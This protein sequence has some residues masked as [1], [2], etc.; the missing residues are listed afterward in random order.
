MIEGIFFCSGVLQWYCYSQLYCCKTFPFHITP[1]PPSR[2]A[3]G[4]G[5]TWQRWVLKF[6]W[7]GDRRSTR[8]PPQS[9]GSACH[10]LLIPLCPAYLEKEAGTTEEGGNGSEGSSCSAAQLYRAN[11]SSVHPPC[12]LNSFQ[13]WLLWY[14]YWARRSCCCIAPSGLHVVPVEIIGNMN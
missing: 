4:G 8:W 9:E 10:L 7:E 12:W 1:S 6:E 11:W 2:P 3:G 5:M 13:R 14:H